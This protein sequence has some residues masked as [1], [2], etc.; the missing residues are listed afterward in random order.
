M[1]IQ[2]SSSIVKAIQLYSCEDI[3]VKV[4]GRILANKCDEEFRLVL[5]QVK[6][7][8]QELL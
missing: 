5:V 6:K 4:F 3:D 8:V 1:V 7:S 2:Y